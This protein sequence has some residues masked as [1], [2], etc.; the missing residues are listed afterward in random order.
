MKWGVPAFDGGKFYIV[1]LKDHVNLGFAIEGLTMEELGLFDG[2]G[3][4]TAHIEINSLNNIDEKR[5]AA[6]LR[7]VYGKTKA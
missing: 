5:I 7:L 2:K 6:L 4:T 3:K 1:A